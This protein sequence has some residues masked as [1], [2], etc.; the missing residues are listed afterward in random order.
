MLWRFGKE[1]RE[2]REFLRY[3][4]AGGVCEHCGAYLNVK[5]MPGEA[6]DVDWRCHSCNKV[7]SMKSFGYDKE[8]EAERTHIFC[9]NTG[10]MVLFSPALQEA[11]KKP[12]IPG[13]FSHIENSVE[14]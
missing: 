6:M 2:M 7:L 12:Y 13:I 3:D 10:I 1:K 14:K 5:G 9:I 11:S 8:E 4:M